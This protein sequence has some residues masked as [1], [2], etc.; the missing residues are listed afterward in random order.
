MPEYAKVKLTVGTH[1][2]VED[3]YQRPT[4]DLGGVYSYQA[5]QPG[6][7]LQAQL[8]LRKSLADKLT[9]NKK[10]WYKNFDGEDRIGQSKKDD[11]GAVEIKVINYE[12]NQKELQSD[13]QKLVV[14]LL[15]DVL[16]RDERLRPSTSIDNLRKELE[17]HLGVEFEIQ[18]EEDK[19]L[20]LIARQHRIESWQVRWGLPRPSLVGIAAGTCVVFKIKGDKQIEV[21]KLLEIESCGIGERRAEGYGQI[22]FNDPILIQETSNFKRKDQGSNSQP[23]NNSSSS[24]SGQLIV[25]SDRAYP[26]ARIIEKSAWREAIRRA[27]LQVA[28]IPN[29]RLG[30]QA[31]KP[32]MSQLGALRAIIGQLQKP[33]PSPEAGIVTRWLKNLEDTPNRKDKWSPQ[34][35]EEIRT[36]VC[37]GN[38]IWNILKL[39]IA[40]ITLTSN[41][42]R[43]L[44]GGQWREMTS[45]Q[46]QKSD[47]LWSEAINTFVDACIRAH[48][49]DLE[50]NSNSNEAQGVELHGS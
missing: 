42:Q 28:A 15:S 12:Q 29:N 39:D 22:C 49:R 3:K 8:R 18:K 23:A 30:I 7:K 27:V 25:E 10:E 16:I 38:R 24:S 43:D 6:T 31:N 44:K 1:N 50:N 37:D 4:S 13:N 14:W 21:S 47:Q 35:L 34:T 45:E 32:T 9:K 36:L 17:I 5:I 20:S 11:Y 33:E 48:K 40:S 46:W 41:G 2:T 26:Y 19:K